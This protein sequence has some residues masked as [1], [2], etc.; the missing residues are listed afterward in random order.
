MMGTLRFT[1]PTF[2]LSCGTGKGAK[3]RTRHEQSNSEA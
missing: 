2:N 1:H 3:R